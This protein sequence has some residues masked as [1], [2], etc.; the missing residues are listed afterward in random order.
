[1]NKL[2]YLIRFLKEYNILYAFL[3][4]YIE[5]R[6]EDKNNTTYQMA[7]KN[8]QREPYITRHFISNAFS[9]D[10]TKQGFAF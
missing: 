9:W 3:D 6:F 4:A 2:Q 5:M 1:M 8:L 7:I 10:K